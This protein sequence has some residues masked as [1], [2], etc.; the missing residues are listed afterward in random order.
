[1]VVTDVEMPRLSGL[2]LAQRIRS[3]PRT[4]ALPVIALSSLAGEED[5]AR[6]REA[7][8]SEYLI[9]LDRDRL[10]AAVR[11]QLATL[12]STGAKGAR[13]SHASLT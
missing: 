11:D 10:L 2:G 5:L 1:M 6:G 9:K 3:D 4:A 7:G 8:A 12:T 13:P